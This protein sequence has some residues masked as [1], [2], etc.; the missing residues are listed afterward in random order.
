[1]DSVVTMPLVVS[2]TGV[3]DADGSAIGELRYWIG[4]R[5]GKTHCSLCEVTH[6]SIRER[7]EWRDLR[8]ALSLDFETVHR[9]EQNKAVAIA[10][11]G[12]FPAVV[13]QD[14]T[15]EVHLLLDAG[16]IDEIARENNPQDALV[17]AIEQAGAAIGLTWPGGSLRK[18]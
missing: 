14:V 8:T 12:R 11:C 9:D 13:A 5:L 3:Y 10:T 18:P 15:G 7:R 6:S 16:K 1:M 4:A 17:A 2:L